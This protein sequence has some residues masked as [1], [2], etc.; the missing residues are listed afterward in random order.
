MLKYHLEDTVI[1]QRNTRI[2]ERYTIKDFLINRKPGEDFDGSGFFIALSH[3]GRIYT[4]NLTAS[5]ILEELLRG[6]TENE[7]VNF[8]IKT[9]DVSEAQ[10]KN[11][12]TAVIADLRS[13][14]F[15]ASDHST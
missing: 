12:V 15:L 1:A 8:F 5:I 3:Q 4:L 14:S 13:R 7:L 11:D 6:T 10:A 9:F 2:P